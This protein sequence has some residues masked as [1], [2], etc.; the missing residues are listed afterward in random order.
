MSHDDNSILLERF[1]TTLLYKS[2]EQFIASNVYPESEK[3]IVKKQR[4]RM[5][6]KSLPVIKKSAKKAVIELKKNG[7]SSIGSI[8]QNTEVVENLMNAVQKDMESDAA[9]LSEN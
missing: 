2:L 6:K 9:K 7:I 5:L 3:E 4:T 8:T 1:L